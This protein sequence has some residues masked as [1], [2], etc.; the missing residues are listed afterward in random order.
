MWFQLCYNVEFLVANFHIPSYPLHLLTSAH[1]Y[2][3]GQSW[4]EDTI[5]LWDMPSESRTLVY[6][7]QLF[8]SNIIFLLLWEPGHKTHAAGSFNSRGPTLWYGESQ[9]VQ[10]KCAPSSPLPH[11][12]ATSGTMFLTFHN[13]VSNFTYVL[14]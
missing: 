12:H 5:F 11:L 4:K 9:V 14:C 2:W 8:C 1:C 13:Y 7:S 6:A 3:A 10:K